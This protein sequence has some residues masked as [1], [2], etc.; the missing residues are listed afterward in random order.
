[1]RSRRTR[2]Q[3]MVEYAIVLPVF[4]WLTL[5][6]VD[7]GRAMW[8]YTTVAYVA[9]EGARFGTIPSR[10]TTEIESA[11]TARCT[12]MLSNTC[13]TPPVPANLPPNTAAISV[14][15]GTCGSTSSPVIV[16]VTYAFEPAS[17]MIANLWGGGTLDL[18]AASQ[19][20]VE[21]GPAGGCAA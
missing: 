3:A 16:S 14:T 17:L 1:M 21:S 8:A 20:Y 9:R 15:R 5:G 19:M 18:Q 2:A 7:F 10:G 11:V 12:T 13:Y 4:F 6:V